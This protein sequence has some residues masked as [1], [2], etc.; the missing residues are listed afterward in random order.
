MLSHAKWD[1]WNM[2]TKM[3]NS[4]KLRNNAKI[5]W[6]VPNRRGTL[7]RRVCW[8]RSPGGSPHSLWSFFSPDFS[9]ASNPVF[10][11]SFDG[12]PKVSRSP[13]SFPEIIGC[14]LWPRRMWR[15]RS[16]NRGQTRAMIEKSYGIVVGSP[17]NKVFARC[18]QHRPGKSRKI[19]KAR[20]NGGFIDVHVRRL[21][22]L[23]TL[24]SY[25][26]LICFY[27]FAWFSGGVRKRTSHEAKR[28]YIFF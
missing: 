13:R 5:A 23:R 2:F 20:I 4:L 8:D 1:A 25:K 17:S 15:G 19:D 7:L 12:I 14:N 10:R 9:S 27:S 3:I 24:P 26:N 21:T 11:Q 18:L 16:F 28:V 6:T 22:A